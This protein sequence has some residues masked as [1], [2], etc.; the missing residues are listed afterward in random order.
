[1]PSPKSRSFWA[2]L[3]RY[4]LALLGVA[5]GAAAFAVVFRGA[6]AAIFV[7]AYGARDVL[8]A[9]EGLPFYARVLVPALGGALAG[10]LGAI[11][12]RLKGGHG[13]G[14]VM[15]AVA[16]GKGRISLRLTL[17]KALGSWL[18]IVS[19][20]SVG[21]EG[22]LIQFG[23]ALGSTLGRVF[24][25]RGRQVRGLIAAG[26]AAGFAAAYNTPIA[27]VLFVVEVVTGVIALDIV[28]PA[29][30]ATPIATAL[31]RLAIGGGPIYGQRS[32]SMSSNAELA[33]Y[34]TLG[35]LAGV[36]GPLFMWLL[37]HGETLFNQ[38]SAKPLRA[39]LGGALVGGTAIVWPQVTG[40]GYEAIN[41]I[42]GERLSIGL[43]IVLL[44]AKAF[45]TTASVSSGS[46]G[47]VFTPSLF[48]GAALGGA[49]GHV[50]LRFAPLSAP[51]AIAAYSLVGMAT[52]I[53]AT[54]HAPVMATV[55]VFELSG[56]YAI[57]LPL[58]TACS[59]AT[60][61]S[62][63]LHHESIY[64]EELRR[65]GTRWEVRVVAEGDST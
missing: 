15:E 59:I 10:F 41:L 50:V 37:S 9:F 22:P 24:Q 26:A 35:L 53:A 47:G 51:N 27:A 44:F 4:A 45:A 56:D 8:A 5:M 3:L 49:L 18:A 23:G 33:I 17:L 65:R 48:L 38:I 64:T 40:N 42:L 11:A 62:R 13:V 55:L 58:L 14:E 7:H 2:N 61:V 1:M 54:T 32:F 21:R 31:T 30:I 19:G 39:A 29:I 25:L 6:I 57:V 28:L 52:L 36:T 20:G 63:W 12:A 16:L 60:L 43:V 34:A 46:P